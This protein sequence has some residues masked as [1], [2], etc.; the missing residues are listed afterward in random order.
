MYIVHAMSLSTHCIENHNILETEK[1]CIKSFF[2]QLN[3]KIAT[4]TWGN[5]LVEFLESPHL[6]RG[7]LQP[8]HLSG[9]LPA[10]DRLHLATNLATK[11]G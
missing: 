6:P 3:G 5:D 1:N 2:C 11:K 10:L 4:K 7:P 8:H 9:H